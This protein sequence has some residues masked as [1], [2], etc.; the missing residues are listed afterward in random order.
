MIY[1]LVYAP[2]HIASQRL[3]QE[4]CLVSAPVNR[5][6]PL[7]VGKG[8]PKLTGTAPQKPIL[9]DMSTKESQEYKRYMIP[10]DYFC[11]LLYFFG[12]LI[13]FLQEYFFGYFV[14]R[15]YHPNHRILSRWAQESQPS[16]SQKTCKV[17]FRGDHVIDITWTWYYLVAHFNWH[18][19]VF[20]GKKTITHSCPN[21]GIN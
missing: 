12:Y 15:K 8:M 17:K 3:D 7:I 14:L 2:I 10:Y 13:P 11:R 1:R 5:H 18:D 21:N 19:L 9:E 16:D 20:T 6:Y 4:T